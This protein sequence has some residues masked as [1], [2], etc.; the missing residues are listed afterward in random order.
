MK[1]PKAVGLFSSA[2]IRSLQLAPSADGRSQYWQVNFQNALKNVSSRPG[3]AAKDG[4]VDVFARRKTA[5]R[6]YWATNRH[7]KPVH[8]EEVGYD[9]RNIARGQ[10]QPMLSDASV[11]TSDVQMPFVGRF[12]C[13]LAHWL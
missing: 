4:A 3:G 13:L 9:I 12:C 11:M 10:L 2:T 7:G 1:S 8:A 5:S 6:N